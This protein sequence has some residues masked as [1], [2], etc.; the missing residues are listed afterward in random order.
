MPS[1]GV[2]AYLQKDCM[3]KDTVLYSPPSEIRGST[4]IAIQG[5][6]P[7]PQSW[8]LGLIWEDDVVQPPG[9]REALLWYPF[10]FLGCRC[11]VGACL[12]GGA[13]LEPAFK[14]LFTRH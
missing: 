10:E 4:A 2:Q 7:R 14:N 1:S 9:W 5:G 3:E 11:H 6:Q 13:E 12:L 8:N